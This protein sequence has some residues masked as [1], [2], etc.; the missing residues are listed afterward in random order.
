MLAVFLTEPSFEA[1][2]KHTAI[3]YEEESVSKRVDRLE[4]MSIPSD[5]EDKLKYASTLLPLYNSGSPPCDSF[6]R[7]KVGFLIEHWQRI[8]M[9][10]ER[11]I[12]RREAEAVRVPPLVRRAYLPA[13]FALPPFA[14]PLSPSTPA[15]SSSASE[16]DSLA[17]S[18]FGGFARTRVVVDAQA[19]L[20][21][22]T[23]TVKSLV[24]VNERCWRG[25]ECELCAGVRQ[26]LV[27]SATHLQ[28][29]SDTLEHR[30]SNLH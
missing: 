15:S 4:E 23:N 20:A 1:W 28:K 2:R 5:L 26:G 24:E 27:D 3:S 7:G 16:T 13:H 14:S 6:V 22:L 18:I 12:R 19:D 8:C 11:I 9:L 10:A 29:H 30:V 21:R 17:S 25:D